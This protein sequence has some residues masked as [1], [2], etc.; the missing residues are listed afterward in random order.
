[1]AATVRLFVAL[2]ILVG[3]SDAGMAQRTTGG[4]RATALSA[5]VSKAQTA[6]RDTAALLTK[7][8][9]SK[10]ASCLQM[11]WLLLAG[12]TL[13]A[14]TTRAVTFI[15]RA[16]AAGDARACGQAAWLLRQGRGVRADT[17]KAL[18][19]FNIACDRRDAKA[20][21]SLGY[22]HEMGMGTARD[23][24]QAA[25]YYDRGCTGGD[26]RGCTNL[27][28]LRDSTQEM[29]LSS[30]ASSVSLLRDSCTRKDALA[31]TNLG[32]R[33]ERGRGMQA[34]PVRAVSLYTRACQDNVLEACLNLGKMTALGRG[35]AKAD[36]VQAA[37]LFTQACDG[38]VAIGCANLAVLQAQGSGLPRDSARAKVL[39]GKACALGD[40]ASCRRAQRP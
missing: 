29:V 40:T 33:L 38:N 28:N 2:L 5:S 24:S 30:G 3:V 12:K 14:D 35:M 22:M 17:A 15:E 34:N 13:P 8:E 11:A 25:S 31:C 26:R 10:S 7:C 21:T 23:V 39:Y 19:L 36:P 6:A 1:L 18:T 9:A 32:V 27:V 4:T 16:C 37:R 20:C